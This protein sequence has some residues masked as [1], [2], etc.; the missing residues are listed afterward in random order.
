MN[1]H[2]TS[3]RLEQ[4][5]W[6]SIAEICSRERTGLGELCFTIDQRRVESTLT[7]ALRSYVV[8]YFRS[9]AT[10]EGHA[11]AG[12]GTFHKALNGR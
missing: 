12:H 4:T 1:G 10:E 7:A 9:A 11:S 6:D 3:L 8:K 5:M 2:R